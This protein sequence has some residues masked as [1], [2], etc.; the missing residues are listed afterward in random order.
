MATRKH[1]LIKKPDPHL[2]PLSSF[3]A[4]LKLRT[5]AKTHHPW[6][7]QELEDIWTKVDSN[8]N[9]V[10]DE[11][12]FRDAL[13]QKGGKLRDALEG[14]GV[15]WETLFS[16]MDKD[17]DGQL[18]KREFLTAFAAEVTIPSPAPKRFRRGSGNMPIR[19]I[20]HGMDV[21]EKGYITKGDFELA[22]TS[23]KEQKKRYK[24]LFDAVG[25]PWRDVFKL[26][27]I[28][29][30][31]RISFSEFR[32]ACSKAA[33]KM[34]RNIDS[35]EPENSMTRASSHDTVQPQSEWFASLERSSRVQQADGTSFNLS[36]PYERTKQDYDRLLM[37]L[38][39][40][41]MRTKLQDMNRLR[42]G[43]DDIYYMAEGLWQYRPEA[44]VEY[45]TQMV[46]PNGAANG[47]CSVCLEPNGAEWPRPEDI[48]DE[49]H[50]FFG[51]LKLEKLVYEKLKDKLSALRVLIDEWR[52]LQSRD[53]QVDP[54][55]QNLAL[56]LNYADYQSRFLE[57]IRLAFPD[58]FKILKSGSKSKDLKKIF[59]A[60]KE[61]F[62]CPE[63]LQF[64]LFIRNSI[65]YQHQGKFQD[66]EGVNSG[67]KSHLDSF[68]KK[69][70]LTSKHAK[71]AVNSFAIA[72]QVAKACEELLTTGKDETRAG[73]LMQMAHQMRTY[74]EARGHVGNERYTR[75]HS[76]EC[77][78]T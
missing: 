21:S 23:D 34:G 6:A 70:V 22:M 28:N 56:F 31:D 54:Y 57:T 35:L 36:Y 74:A 65:K 47:D 30:D 71:Q 8:G 14:R 72:Y 45:R 9:G 61:A 27:D 49:C 15:R 43:R 73:E 32:A 4:G 33:S 40:G 60:M 12:E 78:D 18:S 38:V 77:T 16:R 20:F 46:Q 50:L 64:L 63:I 39:D 11:G 7:F 24:K 52:L 59:K 68:I 69:G 53:P 75:I 29:N 76:F 67:V 37:L 44:I 2:A 26:L 1:H 10:L 17:G 19:A 5:N 62:D 41:A 51:R 48:A 66:I 25:M 58:F 42:K 3:G 55:P 13:H